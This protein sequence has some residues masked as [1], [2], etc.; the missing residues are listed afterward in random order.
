MVGYPFEFALVLGATVIAVFA[1]PA[2]QSPALLD[3]GASVDVNWVA[4]TIVAML[5]F[6]MG[7]HNAL[8]RKHGVPDI[9]TNVMTLTFA[10]LISESALAGGQSPRWQRR[11]SSILLFMAGAALG[12]YLLTINIAAPLVLAT[13][14]FAVALYPLTRGVIEGEALSGYQ[15]TNSK[16]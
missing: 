3:S 4:V 7:I 6:A 13:I 9:A 15:T 2:A 8:M 12:S 10:G 5:A 1:Q 11:L 16:R 14:I